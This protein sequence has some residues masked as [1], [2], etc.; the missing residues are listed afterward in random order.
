MES[1][2]LWGFIPKVLKLDAG[3]AL[4]VNQRRGA[5][6]G[7]EEIQFPC[8]RDGQCATV[9]AELAADVVDVGLDCA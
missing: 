5:W 1:G 3:S 8:P 2:G 9:N 6:S 7:L 4:L